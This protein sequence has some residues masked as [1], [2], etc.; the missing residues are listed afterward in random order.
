MA[1]PTPRTVE[2]PMGEAI[3]PAN[4]AWCF[5]A[6]VSY[7]WTKGAISGALKAKRAGEV[8]WLGCLGLVARAGREAFAPCHLSLELSDPGPTL[9]SYA[10]IFAGPLLERRFASTLPAPQKL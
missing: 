10:N 6:G 9:G 8:G 7:A 2:L 5:K 3:Q 4:D 1:E